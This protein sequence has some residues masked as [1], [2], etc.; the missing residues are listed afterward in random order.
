MKTGWKCALATGA[1][2][3]ACMLVGTQPGH[4][5]DNNPRTDSVPRAL[6][7]EGV[8]AVDGVPLNGTLPVTFRLWGAPEPVADE[9]ALYEETLDVPFVNGRFSVLLGQAQQGLANAIFDADALYVG[10]TVGGT[11]LRGRQRIVPVPYALWAAK[12]ADFAV[13]GELSIDGSVAAWGEPRE[14]TVFASNLAPGFAQGSIPVAETDG[15]L[16]VTMGPSPNGCSERDAAIVAFEGNQAGNLTS[17][18][19]TSQ[20]DCS[21]GVQ[22]MSLPVRKGSKYTVAIQSGRIYSRAIFYPLGRGR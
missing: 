16:M 22:S 8:L 4:A 6:P 20:G 14:V 7:Y 18:Q 3:L 17:S 13:A 12:A 19:M 11:T 10:I 15:L 1:F 5:G 2:T 9:V 21:M